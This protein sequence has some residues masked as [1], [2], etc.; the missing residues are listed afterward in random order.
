MEFIGLG[1]VAIIAIGVYFVQSSKKAMRDPEKF[2]EYVNSKGY[3]VEQQKDFCKRLGIDYEKVAVTPSRKASPTPTAK[4]SIASESSEVETLT[5][6]REKA[7]YNLADKILEDDVV[8]LEE[9]KKLRAWFKRYPESKEDS[10]TKE[11]AATVELYLEDKVLDNDEALHLF[12]LLTDFCDG[13]EEREQANQQP[14]K[15]PAPKS[16]KRINV[17]TSSNLSFLNEL[18]LDAQYFMSYK[19]SAG[20]VSDREIVLRKIEQNAS[21]DTYVKAF[22]L[23]RNSIRTFRADRITGIC[24]VE[25]GEAFV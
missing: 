7:L 12:A 6:R 10:K 19:D 9:S 14:K 21:G 20:K 18:E 15:K 2:R 3:D 8:D 25:T 13:F 24:S 1:L 11:L 17:A 4:K 5:P 22:C 23:M 16:G